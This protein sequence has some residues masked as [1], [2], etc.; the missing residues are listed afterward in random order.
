MTGGVGNSFGA[1]DRLRVGDATYNVCRLDRFEG[2]GWLPHALSLLPETCFATRA[3]D[4]SLMTRRKPLRS[5]ILQYVPR[6][7]LGE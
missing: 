2:A 7:L 6:Q 4:W 1:W 5:G 3:A